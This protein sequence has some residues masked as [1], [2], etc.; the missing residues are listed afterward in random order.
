[1]FMFMD[2]FNWPKWVRKYKVQPGTNEPVDLN[3]LKA[4]HDQQ[5]QINCVKILMSYSVCLRQLKWR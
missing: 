5:T 2:Y 3:K 1:M 4:V